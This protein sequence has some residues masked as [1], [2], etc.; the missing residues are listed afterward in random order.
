VGKK[1]NLQEKGRLASHS[2]KSGPNDPEKIH[3]DYRGGRELA[4]NFLPEGGEKRNWL[5]HTT[6]GTPPYS[7]KKKG[8]RH[9]RKRKAASTTN[10]G[11]LPLSRLRE[12]KWYYVKQGGV[13]SKL[14]RLGAKQKKGFSS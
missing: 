11:R 10:Q 14:L 6:K 13:P 5:H 9:G 12:A 4:H 7:Q 1:N 2:G 8:D 3:A